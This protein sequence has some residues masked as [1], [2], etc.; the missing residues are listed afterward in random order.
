MNVSMSSTDSFDFIL[1]D[2]PVLEAKYIKCPE[3][4][5]AGTKDSN[6]KLTKLNDSLSSLEI[7]V[8]SQESLDLP[9]EEQVSSKVSSNEGT[10]T[11]SPCKSPDSDSVVVEAAVPKPNNATKTTSEKRTK[12]SWMNVSKSDSNYP[13]TLDKLLSL[14]QP[15]N[16][17][18]MFNRSSP[19]NLK[20]EDSTTPSRK[21]SAVN[22]LFAMV[23]FGNSAK[24][25]SPDNTENLPIKSNVLQPNQSSSDVSLVE[26]TVSVDHLSNELKKEVKENISPE[27]TITAS[28]VTNIK[29]QSPA[30]VPVLLEEKIEPN[31]Q[32]KVIF[33]LGGEEQE[34]L[35]SLMNSSSNQSEV[36]QNVN[37]DTST[38]VQS[39]DPSEQRL[40]PPTDCS[41]NNQMGLPGFGLGNIARDSLSIIKGGTNTSQ[42]SMRSLDSL[43]EFEQYD[44][45]NESIK[46][47]IFL[48][49]TQ[50]PE[51]SSAPLA[52]ETKEEVPINNSNQQR[53]D[54][55]TIKE[56][57]ENIRPFY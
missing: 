25:E 51:N 34:E 56:S 54:E 39:K 28:S 50:L 26:H 24:K 17:S 46:Q 55:V 48:S 5:S 38:V 11:N 52:E 47:P 45:G 3:P 2:V 41:K 6:N 1:R 33:E 49:E 57:D 44:S 16:I 15:T 22:N 20:K 37:T 14:F 42:D 23:G 8:S 43:P 36:L 30:N 13:A 32:H 12:N 9:Q 18:Q 40:T 27:N 7:S 35:L 19:D 53:D 10:L 31:V 4:V 29:P 21:D